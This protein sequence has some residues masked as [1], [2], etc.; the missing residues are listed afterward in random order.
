MRPV[1]GPYEPKSTAIPARSG[2]LAP[3]DPHAVR[4]ASIVT[5]TAIATAG[6]VAPGLRGSCPR[7]KSAGAAQR[8]VAN[9]SLY[10]SSIPPEQKRITIAL[11]S[12]PRKLRKRF[13]CGGLGSRSDGGQASSEPAR[14]GRRDPGQDSDAAAMLD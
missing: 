14:L 6:N 3:T 7:I 1:S 13:N 8:R 9:K 4:P 12:D 2:F 10:Q 5:T 11:P